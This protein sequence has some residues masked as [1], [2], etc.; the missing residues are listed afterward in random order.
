[1]WSRS[2]HEFGT[3]KYN[4]VA[5]WQLPIKNVFDRKICRSHHCS[6][7]FCL[8]VLESCTELDLNLL[9]ILISRLYSNFVRENKMLALGVCFPQP[10]SSAGREFVV[11][12]GRSHLDCLRPISSCP[13]N[14]FDETLCKLDS[15]QNP[16]LFENKGIPR[17]CQGVPTTAFL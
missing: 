1:M 13:Q 16:R 11:D 9:Y 15:T 4:A 3:F 5:K 12:T 6:T 8:Q 14:E 7:V 17:V 10:C 2:V